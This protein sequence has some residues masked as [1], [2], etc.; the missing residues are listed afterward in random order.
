MESKKGRYIF[1]ILSVLCVMLI[2]LSSVKDGLMNPIRNTVGYILVP[3]Q[4]GVNRA[5]RIIYERLKDRRG[6]DEL[7]E[8]NER[9]QSRLDFLTEENN[10]LQQN[11]EELVRLRELYEL[12]QEYA[13]YRKVAARIIAKDSEN[14]F[15]VFRI[16][17]GSQDGIRV[18]QNVMANGGLVGIIT[19]VGL[20]YATVRSIIDDESRVSCMGMRSSDTCIVAG[21]LTL[22]QEGR[23]RITN[24]EKDS[25][26]REGDR[27]VTSNI[28]SRFMPGILVGYAMDIEEDS[29]HLMKNGYLVPAA[30]FNDLRE[31]LIIIDVKSDQF[32][33]ENPGTLNELP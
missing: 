6:L 27:I 5:G 3:V 17:K 33:D 28:S 29:K 7:K 16:D 24:L 14:W 1:L 10:I 18:D 22:F 25:S 9:L 13:S 31:V 2:I 32:L 30:D 8:E 19:D 15:H 26:I 11:A 23:L 4:T 12:D 20:N 21:D